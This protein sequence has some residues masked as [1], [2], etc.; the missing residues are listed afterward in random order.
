MAQIPT[1]APDATVADVRAALVE[2]ARELIELRNR[3]AEK[4]ATD[5]HKLEEADVISFIHTADE[6][7][8]ALG[9]AERQADAEFRAAER[10]ARTKAKGPSAAFSDSDHEGRSAGTQFISHEQ[11]ADWSKRGA[12]GARGGSF[13]EVEIRGLLSS[14]SA[15][16]G[17]FRP[18]GTP[19]LY[20]GAIQMRKMWLRDLMSVQTTGLSSVPYIQEVNSDFN[21]G[22]ASAVAEASS[23]PE[24]SMQFIQVDAPVRKIAGWLRATDEILMDAPTLKGYIDTRL[25]YMIAVAE[26]QQIL[27]GT[28]T[29]PQLQGLGGL[30]GT[31]TQTTPTGDYPAIIGRAIG[32]V[33]NVDGD[34]DGVATNPLDY[35]TAVTTRYSTNFDNAGGG[36]SAPA[37]AGN[38]TWGL[39][40]V[41]TRA[42]TAGTA[43]VA[44]W[45]LGSTL[46]DRMQ[47][48]IR[49]A[50]Q[51]DDL[52]IKN[53]IVILAEERVAVA[54]HR[55]A[56]FVKATVPAGS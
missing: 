56:L 12:Q 1:L 19:E 8:K 3:P 13:P 2:T 37:A 22:G 44:A 17:V 27:A 47:T 9:A 43:W 30:S 23:K 18:V 5:E 45:K 21:A 7:E 40:A 53:Q 35:W 10:L 31:Q 52:F 36:S 42:L 24:V 20:P 41:R 28:G 16:G 55:P 14:V 32:K 50:E 54:W 46:F 51:H 26:E 49:V 38:V 25:G 15:E 11:Y 48:V 6:I 34:P 39:P 29:A 4:R 33:E